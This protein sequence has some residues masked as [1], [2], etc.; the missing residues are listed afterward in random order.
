MIFESVHKIL[1][2]LEIIRDIFPMS[3]LLIGREISKIYEEFLFFPS[4]KDL[5]IDNLQKK[6]EFVVLINNRLKK[7]AKENSRFTET[8][9]E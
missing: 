8:I 5:K 2:L 9:I 6:G 3:N 7:I 4:A 1:D